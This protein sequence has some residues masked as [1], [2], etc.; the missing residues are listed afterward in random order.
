MKLCKFA[1]AVGI[2]AAMTAASVLPAHAADNAKRD[3]AHN[4]HFYTAIMPGYFFASNGR[5]TLRNGGTA[6]IL[7]GYQFMPEMEVEF[8]LFGT[9]IFTPKGAPANNYQSGFT[10]D[11]AYNLFGT[12]RTGFTPFVIAGVGAVHDVVYQGQ[13]TGWNFQAD[14]GLGMVT[15][16][17]FQT[18]WFNGLKIRAEA[19]WLYDNFKNAKQKGM[20]DARASI[21]IELPIGMP[22]PPPPPPP[23][24]EPKVKVVKEKVKVIRCPIPFP[25]AKLDK[26]GCAIAPQTVVLAGV[27]FAYNKATLRPDA[28]TILNQ[29]AGAMKSQKSLTVEIEGHTDDIGSQKYNLKLSQQRAD[30]VR[31]YLVAQGVDTSRLETKGYGESK[32]IVTPQNTA[33]AR[34]QNRRVEFHI[35]T[36]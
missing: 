7:G 12:D 24:P 10:F 26:H 4:A 9:K 32:P 6:S 3:Y 1:G 15:G 25:G 8:N 22:A 28:K 20:S 13:Y 35:L 29:V 19:R 5:N 21:G 23:P 36:P 34:A 17:L 2:A 11:L 27:H 33:A 18:G 31:D 14:A 16:A 30:S